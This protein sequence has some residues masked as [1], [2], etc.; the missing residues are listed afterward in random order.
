MI[1][2]LHNWLDWLIGFGWVSAVLSGLVAV[3]RY[4]QSPGGRVDT[5][6]EWPQASRVKLDSDRFTLLMFLHPRCDCSRASLRQLESILS[7]IPNQ[8]SAHVLFYKPLEESFAWAQTDIWRTAAV[9][10]G[11]QLV[12][13]NES[14]ES[15]TFGIVTAGQ[16]VL[17]DPAV[18]LHFSGV[19]AAACC[20]NS[21]HLEVPN[22]AQI[23]RSLSS[24]TPASPSLRMCPVLQAGRKSV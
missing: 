18:K 9:M 3:W 2:R 22:L 4:E 17:Y 8:I 15:E 7:D 20:K 19:I 12:I 6:A 14:F 23:I 21:P 16:V 1:V 11:V 10:R 13:D 5:P 24:Q